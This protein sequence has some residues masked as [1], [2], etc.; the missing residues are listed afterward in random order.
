MRHRALVLCV[1]LAAL[2]VLAGCSAFAPVR[3]TDSGPDDP[4]VL[5]DLAVQNYDNTSHTVELVVL[6]DEEGVVHWTTREIEGKSRDDTRGTVV[7]GA[8]VDP[9]SVAN[10]T[11]EYTV[12]VRLDSASDGVRYEVPP[13]GA[14][15]CYSLGVHIRDGKL[16]GP[17]TNHWNDDHGYCSDP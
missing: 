11:R 16:T 13:D 2:L 10:S 17:M 15:D 14:S 1:A 9:P 7:D 12:L 4:P 8:I 3:G 5:R 6:D